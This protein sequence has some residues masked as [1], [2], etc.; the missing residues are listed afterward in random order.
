VQTVFVGFYTTAAVLFILSGW[1]FIRTFNVQ[2]IAGNSSGRPSGQNKGRALESAS[3]SG[4][5]DAGF[6]DTD[7]FVTDSLSAIIQYTL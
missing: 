7:L 6:G 4:R 3:K 2:G 1:K 5:L